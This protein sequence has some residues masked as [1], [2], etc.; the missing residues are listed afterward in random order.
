MQARYWEALEGARRGK[1]GGGG[2]GKGGGDGAEARE[3]MTSHGAVIAMRGYHHAAMLSGGLIE[4]R[5]A[6]SLVLGGRGGERR[7]ER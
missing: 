3:T 1:S 5:R 6:S 7:S 2:G 4:V